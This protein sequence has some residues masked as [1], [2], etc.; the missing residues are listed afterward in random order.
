MRVYPVPTVPVFETSH[1]HS[2]LDRQTLS[3]GNQRLGPLLCST[4]LHKIDDWKAK[5]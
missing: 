5:S 4:V 3:I 2:P 1:W